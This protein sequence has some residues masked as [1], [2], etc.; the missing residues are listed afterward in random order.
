MTTLTNLLVNWNNFKASFAFMGKGML[1]IFI[2][3]TVLI[4]GINLLN[5]ATSA[6]KK[7]DDS[8]NQ[9]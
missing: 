4:V 8:D 5:K 7:K 9:E 1:G 3:I 6:I 2:V